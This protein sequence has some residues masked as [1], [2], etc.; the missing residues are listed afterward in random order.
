MRRKK[1]GLDLLSERHQRA[2]HEFWLARTRGFSMSVDTQK[3]INEHPGFVFEQFDNEFE[4]DPLSRQLGNP[5]N[6]F[7]PDSRYSPSNPTPP[8]TP[9]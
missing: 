5:R 7:C 3:F 6:F 8:P 1:S 9:P 4:E 2:C